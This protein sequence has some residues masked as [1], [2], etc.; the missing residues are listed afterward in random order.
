MPNYGNPKYWDDRYRD[1]RSTTFDWLE[2]YENLKELIQEK[3]KKTDQILMLGCGNAEL[4]QKM[5]D[6]GYQNII[7]IDISSVV[8]EQMKEINKER[9]KMTWHVMD[10]L[11][12]EFEDKKFDAVIDKSTIDAILCG[13][14]SF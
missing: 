14:Y 11:K 12:M 9:T 7:N 6:D 13:Q 5:Y 3:I 4:S 8:I 2:D 1:K 10:A